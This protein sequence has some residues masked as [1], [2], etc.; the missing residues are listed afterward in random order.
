MSDKLAEKYKMSTGAKV[1]NAIVFTC[2]LLAMVS[3]ILVGN[4]AAA[5]WVLIAAMW[6]GMNIAQEMLLQKYRRLADLQMELTDE[7]IKQN[8]E[9]TAQLLDYKIKEVRKKEVKRAS[10]NAKHNRK[11]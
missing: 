7:V 5:I 11:K 2:L 10:T 6:F 9:L 8:N 4:W 3:S 1:A